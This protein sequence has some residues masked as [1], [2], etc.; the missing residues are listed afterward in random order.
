MVP[1]A[2]ASSISMA[3]SRPRSA[4][5]RDA[6]WS[7]SL[8]ESRSTASTPSRSRT[9][10][11]VLYTSSSKSVHLPENRFGRSM[12][13]RCVAGLE[14]RKE[15]R[16]V[17]RFR[18]ASSRM[19]R[20]IIRPPHPRAFIGGHDCVGVMAQRRQVLPFATFMSQWNVRAATRRNSYA[21]SR[22]RISRA[23]LLPN[24]HV[25][26]KSIATLHARPSIAE[27]REPSRIIPTSGANSPAPRR[28]AK[29]WTT[30]PLA[31]AAAAFFTIPHEA[32]KSCLQTER[33]AVP[34]GSGRRASMAEADMTMRGVYRH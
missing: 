30:R 19:I 8:S 32:T 4:T 9:F 29:R 21:P 25:G 34:W 23:G 22:Y 28:I 18:R 26:R 27:V 20:S 17:C 31:D 24:G 1:A 6:I 3:R 13:V 14:A 12:P 33:V 10:S 5:T 7:I 11:N 15:L 16:E 2:T